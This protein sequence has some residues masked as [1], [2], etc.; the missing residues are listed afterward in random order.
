MCLEELLYVGM[1]TLLIVGLS[2][3]RVWNNTSPGESTDIIR[4]RKENV[5]EVFAHVIITSHAQRCGPNFRVLLTMKVKRYKHAKKVL[6]FYKNTFG[7]REPFQVL[8][9]YQTKTL[10]TK[11]SN[12]SLLILYSG[13]D[14][15]SSS[16]E[17]ENLHQR[18]TPKVLWRLSTV[19]YDITLQ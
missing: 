4:K 7:F 17:R 3:N 2:K 12:T 13:R 11:H 19:R 8:G 14:V 18:T 1:K 10:Q 5:A 16:T 15:L 6:S 9:E